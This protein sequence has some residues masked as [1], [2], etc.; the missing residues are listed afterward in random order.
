MNKVNQ[1]VVPLQRIL[2]NQI[3]S[4]TRPVTNPDCGAPEIE[5]AFADRTNGLADNRIKSRSILVVGSSPNPTARIN[6]DAGRPSCKLLLTRRLA[7][8]SE[9]NSTVNT[10]FLSF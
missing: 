4:A 10:E 2:A 5:G 6:Q 9:Q 8:P 7:H 1:T 3:Y